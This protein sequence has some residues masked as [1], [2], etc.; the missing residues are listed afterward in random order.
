VEVEQMMAHLFEEMRTIQEMM[1]DGQGKMKVQVCSV[2][3][4]IDVSQEKLMGM[5]DTQPEKIGRLSRKDGGH[6][7]G[8]KSRRNKAKMVH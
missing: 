8:G 1:D 4:Q 2:T 5:M 3:S 7:F 6:G